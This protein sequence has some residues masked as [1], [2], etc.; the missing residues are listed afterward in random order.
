[1]IDNSFIYLCRKIT[2]WE[3]YKKPLTAHLFIHC[4][5]R[6]NW[7]DARFEGITV[8]RGS[9]VTSYQILAAESGLSVSQV[10]SGLKHLILTRELTCVTSGKGTIISVTNY[11]SYQDVDTILS[12]RLTRGSHADRTRLTTSNTVNTPNTVNE[13][14]T[15]SEDFET[16]W[17]LFPSGH[18][19][20]KKAALK[21]YK[22]AVPKKISADDLLLAVKDY[23]ASVAGKDPQYT[24]N[25]ANW[26]RDECWDKE[27]HA[28]G[29]DDSDTYYGLTPKQQAEANTPGGFSRNG[30]R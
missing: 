12:R 19:D 28:D 3:W 23:S 26:L 13:G 18:K 6:A 8:K 5:I 27:P 30:Y 21:Y 22:Q 11:D 16:F 1:M 25:P 20:R 15:Y 2:K 14:N 7:E 29:D 24:K 10:R 9:F 17:R 4:I